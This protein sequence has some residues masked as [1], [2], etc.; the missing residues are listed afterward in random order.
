MATKPYKPQE[1]EPQQVNEPVVAYQQQVSN[2]NLYEP[3]EFERKIILNSEKDYREGCIYTQEEV[4]K[5]MK[6]WLS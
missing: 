4:D 2:T 3:T 6:E 5:M 1:G